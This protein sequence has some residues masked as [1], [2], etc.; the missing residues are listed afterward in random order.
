MSGSLLENFTHY[1]QAQVSRP[2]N[3]R[4]VRPLGITISREAGAGAVTIA[5]LVPQRLTAAETE[6]SSNPWAVFDAN[7]AKKVL[8]DHQLPFDLARFMAED[9]RLP[10]E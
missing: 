5:E 7:L 1:L 2:E 9:A 6:P 10:V 4:A 8:K 3:E